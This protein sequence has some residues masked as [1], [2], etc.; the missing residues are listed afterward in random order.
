M[1]DAA[2]DE[3]INLIDTAECYGDHLSE[4]LVGRAIE[5]DRER[6][7]LAT[8]F[9]H[10]YHGAFDRTEPR[11]PDDIRTQLDDSLRALRT[12]WIDLYQ[13][14]S[15]GDD[16]F[17]NQDVH[18]LLLELKREG[19][20]KHIGNSVGSNTNAKQ[21]EAS[22]EREIEAIQIIYNRMDKGPEER[23]F[24]LCREQDLGVLARV[25]LASGYLSGKYE[26]GHKFDK[27]EVRG[28]RSDEQNDA[29]L[30]E[31]QRIKENEVPDGVPM[32]Q[33]ALAWVLKHPAVTC[34]IPAARTSSRS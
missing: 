4:Q 33:W 10:K 28:R 32:V 22:N 27:E 29:A 1:F 9:G 31:A 24:D 7:V 21:V 12:E 19:K 20:I 15:W 23:V 18:D 5:R 11:R 26:P 13:Y 14:H 25:P 34:V 2:R 8:K 16:D 17:F 3:G 30:E 6:W